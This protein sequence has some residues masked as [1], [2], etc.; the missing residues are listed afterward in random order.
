MK[1]KALEK[2]SKADKFMWKMASKWYVH[3]ACVCVNVRGFQKKNFHKII[4]HMVQKMRFC[5]KNTFKN[6]QA[7]WNS[8]SDT[9]LP[10][11]MWVAA[12]RLREK[13]L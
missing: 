5:K 6:F 1:T 2:N 11:S 13:V 10:A 3:C 12:C 7:D 8:L 9:C 4:M